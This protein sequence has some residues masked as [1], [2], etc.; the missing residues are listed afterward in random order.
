MTGKASVVGGQQVKIKICGLTRVEDVQAALAAGADA[1]GF[2]FTASP[3]RVS[4]NTAQR[5]CSYV[6][7][8]VL[9]VGLFLNQDSVEID[10]VVGSVPLDLLQFHGTETRQE[11]AAFGLPYLKAVAIQDAQS[12]QVADRAYP[13]ATGLLLDS[14]T[15]GQRGG[16]GKVFDWALLGRV[17]RPRLQAGGLTAENVGRAIR[18][19]RPYAVDV[20]SGVEKAPGIK[21][22]VRISDFVTAVRNAE[23]EG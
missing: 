9:R 23:I 19:L 22:K 14:H 20:S 15:A 10:R 5:L 13:D 3:R 12:L 18:K 21:D 4:V 7:T 6:P 1:L 2:V 8:G 17:T 16:S 11:C